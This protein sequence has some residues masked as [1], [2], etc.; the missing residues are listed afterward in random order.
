[1]SGVLSLFSLEGKTAIC[2]GATRGLGQAMA[3][4][5]AEAG[6]DIVLAQVFF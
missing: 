2:T 5:L 6:A 4:G 3:L 1:M